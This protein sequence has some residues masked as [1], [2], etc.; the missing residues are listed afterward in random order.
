MHINR[1]SIMI[2][3]GS[4]L[5]FSAIGCG[6]RSSLDEGDS[7][8]E[9]TAASALDSGTMEET[10]GTGERSYCG[11][12]RLDLLAGEQCDGTNLGYMTCESLGQG[13]GI[14]RCSQ[15]C[16][17]DVSMCRPPVTPPTQP[18]PDSTTPVGQD[19]TGYGNNPLSNIINL[20]NRDAGADGGRTFGGRNTRN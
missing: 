19:Q 14:L 13:V 3:L 17:F 6:M 8:E 5:A 10:A 20:F 18:P 7:I 16:Y 2:I 4:L 11:D 12:G 15:G 1:R 9:I